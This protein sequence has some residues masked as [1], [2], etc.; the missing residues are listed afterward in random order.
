MN[1]TDKI[2]FSK[3]LNGLAA[4]KPAAKLTPESLELFWR[5]MTDWPLD[6]F[7]LA[8]THLAK[9]CEFMP[10]PFH[11]EQLRKSSKQTA[12]EAWAIALRDCT[13]WRGA[14]PSPGG[15]IDRAVSA[16][17]GYKA[18]AMTSDEAMPFIERRFKDAY[19]QLEDAVTIRE[20]LPNLLQSIEHKSQQPA[21]QKLIA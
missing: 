4:M 3:I 13:C 6:E 20:A 1:A 12:G 15:L 16:I 14:R 5:A 19:E 10:N 2:E 8:A 17:G 11:F 7:K 18:I 21:Q 9:T